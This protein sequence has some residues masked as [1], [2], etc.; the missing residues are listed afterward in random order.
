MKDFVAKRIKKL[1][2][3][4]I[5]QFFDLV[6]KTKD[7]VSL[8]VGEP[9]FVAPWNIR[10]KAIY[11][12]E[13]GYTSYTSNKGLLRLR[14]EI[15]YFL[16][17]HYG[18]VYDAEDEILITTGVSQGLDLAVRAVVNPNDRVLIIYPCY[19]AYPA[20][21][22]IAGGRI[23]GLYTK[24]SEGFKINLKEL[25]A[26]LKKNKPKAMILNYPSNPTGVSYTREELKEIN[27]ICAKHDV[28]VISDEIYDLISYDYKQIPFATLKGAKSRTIYL[29]GFS[30]GYAMTGF[31]VGF[32]CG[33]KQIIAQMAKIHSFVMLCA[34]IISQLAAVEALTSQKEVSLMIREY[35]RR[36]DYITDE[37]NQM[38]LRT[39]LP[40]GAFYCFCSVKQTKLDS[41]EFAKKLLKEVKVAVVPGQAFGSSYKDF[42]RISYACVFEDLKE[43]ISRIKKFKTKLS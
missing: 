40:Q 30:K 16:K 24:E 2:P 23:T 22:E 19:V 42:I 7:V 38:G 25:E 31:R 32:A 37:L 21:V 34:P 26:V 29:N 43:A 36:R 3:S 39:I 4:G 9:D 28:L 11:S 12:L 10:E 41:L 13:Q 27:L 1:A 20:A 33:S 15:A 17:K 8:G 18:L 5:R 35:K 6:L 14:L